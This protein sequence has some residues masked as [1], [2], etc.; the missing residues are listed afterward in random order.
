MTGLERNADVVTMA[1]YAPLFAHVDAWQWTPNL[2]WF[3]NLRS[4]GTPNY[5]VQKLYAT[6]VGTHLAAVTV[7]GAPENAR[8]GLFTSAS[9]DQKSGDL[10]LKLVNPSSAARKVRVEP[11]GARAVP[12]SGRLQVL[13]SADPNAENSLDAPQRVSPAER[14]VAVAGGVVDLTLDAQSFTV[15]RVKVAP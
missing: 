8:D 3:D 11:K 12:A 9:V 10:I 5:Y 15:L 6:N 14:T 13:S 4:Y 7:N 2:I 1:S